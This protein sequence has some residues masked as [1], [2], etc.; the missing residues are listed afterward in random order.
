M[1]DWIKTSDKLPEGDQEVM[2]SG[3]LFNVEN[4]TRWVQP[5]IFFEGTFYPYKD[6]DADDEDVHVSDIGDELHWPSHWQP[7]PAPPAE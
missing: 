7:F 4:S 1:S 6:K 5:G 2:A 3:W